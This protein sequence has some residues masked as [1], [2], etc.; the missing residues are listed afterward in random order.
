MNFLYLIELNMELA[1][2]VFRWQAL[3]HRAMEFL[4]SRKCGEYLEELSVY[5]LVDED[6]AI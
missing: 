6:R 4:G 2:E 1:E 5:Q 3:V